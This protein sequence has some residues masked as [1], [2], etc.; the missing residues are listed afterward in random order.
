[1]ASNTSHTNEPNPLSLTKEDG[2]IT[3]TAPKDAASD[4]EDSVQG[5][6][7][8]GAGAVRDCN[9]NE[10]DRQRLASELLPVLSG[11]LQQPPDKPALSSILELLESIFNLATVFTGNLEHA[12]D[13][14][15]QWLGCLRAVLK[16][17]EDTNFTGNLK[18]RKAFKMTLPT[19]L[20]RSMTQIYLQ[21]RA[22]LSKLRHERKIDNNDFAKEVA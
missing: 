7:L 5:L 16:F 15:K 10:H 18:T 21:H 4:N 8:P 14:F 19:S 22:S 1:M 2:S 17:Y 12:K 3:V 13:S 11:K 20:A 9:D 6:D